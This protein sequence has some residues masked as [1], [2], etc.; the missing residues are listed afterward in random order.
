MSIRVL[1]ADDHAL[2]RSGIRMLLEA[3]PDIEVV[4][5]AGDGEATIA[6]AHRLRPDIVLMDLSMPG[7]NG[8]EATRRIHDAQPSTRVLALTM[9][10]GEQYFFQMLHAGASGYLIKGASPQE[11]LDAVRS[12]ARGQAYL[13]PS[14]TRTLLDDYLRRVEAGEEGDSYHLLSAREREVLRLIAEGKTS[15]Q[16]ADILCL[17]PNTVDRH[18]ANIMGKLNLHSRADLIKYAIRKGLISVET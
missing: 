3:E 6:L 16:V 8:L 11:L 1:V 2:V 7:V 18:R 15:R 17:S 14:L 4:G 10:E 5:E 9:H 12:V 13:N